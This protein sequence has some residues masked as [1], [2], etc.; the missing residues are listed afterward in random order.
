MEPGSTSSRA[1][2]RAGIAALALA[3]AALSIPSLVPARAAAAL[4]SGKLA[5][6]PLGDVDQEAVETAKASIEKA[7]PWTVLVLPSQ[8]LPQSAWYAPRKRY[9]AEKI[10]EWLAPRLPEGSDRIMG[11]T[12]KDISTTKGNVY[13]W[14]ICGLADSPGPAAVVSTYRIK[15]KLGKIPPA[16]KKEKYLQRLRDLATHEFGHTLG[17]PHCPN[18]GCVMEDAKGTVLTFDHS[19]GKLCDDCSKMLEDL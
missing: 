18:K 16:K 1:G 15:K 14:G 11:L 4:G 3:A 5:L 12:R 17:L 9:R 7:F 2:G 13:D 6:L 8:P 19:S 10:L